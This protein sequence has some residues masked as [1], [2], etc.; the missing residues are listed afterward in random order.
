MTQTQC[1]RPYGTSICHLHTAIW[2]GKCQSILTQIRHS[3]EPDMV[4]HRVF[5]FSPTTCWPAGHFSLE[6]PLAQPGGLVQPEHSLSQED[7]NSDRPENA[8]LGPPHLRSRRDA[9]QPPEV[10]RDHLARNT[11]VH[12]PAGGLRCI[13]WN[14][15]GLLGP[16]A[17]S[18]H[19]REQKHIYLTRVA[20]NNDICLQETH[21]KDEFLQAVH[22][23]F[24]PFRLLGAVTL[25]SVNEGGSAFFVHKN[26]LPD[27]AVVNH[28]PTCQGRSHSDH[29]VLVVVNVHFEL[30][31]ERSA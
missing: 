4:C 7:A 29:S 13:S 15:R 2:L 28:T 20:K 12:I 6:W 21:G 30:G 22:I 1:S 9:L 17:S 18:Q 31:I 19:T 27:G 8:H 25:N 14:T 10:L 24:P 3:S 5:P 26:F 16:A 23:L 11:C